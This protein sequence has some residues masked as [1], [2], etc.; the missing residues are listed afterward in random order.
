MK[1]GK[2]PRKKKE[3]EMAKDSVLTGFHSGRIY[4]KRRKAK[5][6][7]AN[8]IERASLRD[9]LSTARND[10]DELSSIPSG[11]I[12]RKKVHTESSNKKEWVLNSRKRKVRAELKTRQNIHEFI[13]EMTKSKSL[14]STIALDFFRYVLQSQPTSPDERFRVAIRKAMMDPKLSNLIE[15]KWIAFDKHFPGT[16][17]SLYW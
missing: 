6:R 9:A 2:D 16:R 12:S 5:K 14:Y 11:K 4:R 8:H 15:K 17:N 10:S 13:L 3:A 7:Y 1:P